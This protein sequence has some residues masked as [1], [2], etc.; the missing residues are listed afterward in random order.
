MGRPRGSGARS[1]VGGR[2]TRAGLVAL[3]CLPPRA[4]HAAPPD[5]PAS[6]AER[7]AVIRAAGPAIARRLA[8]PQ[9]RAGISRQKIDS[10]VNMVDT[11][12]AL[13]YLPSIMLRKR[14][15]G[16]TQA[17]VETRT[18]GVNS[19]ARSLVYVDDAPISALI[20]NNNTSGGPR[21]GM[22]A[23]EQI[24]RIDVL[25]GPFAAAYPGNAM[26]GVILITT[27]MPD[28]FEAT[29]RQGGGAQT[30]AGYRTHGTYGTATTAVTLG[31][32]I[33]RLSWFVS[34]NR[35]E[36]L[37][38]PL[39]FVTT[40]AMPRGAIPALSKTGAVANVAGA[41][42]LQHVTMNTVTGRLA[43]DITDWLRATYMVGYWTD[44]GRSRAQTYLRTAAG[45]AT[46]GGIGGFANGIY[47]LGAAHLSNMVALRTDTRGTWDGE[48]VFTAYDY[49]HDW[50]RN[51]AGVLAGTAL[52][53]GGAIASMAGSGWKTA[54]GRATWRPDAAHEVSF[55]GHWDRYMLEN[56][57]YDTNDW[58]ASATH[59]N[60]TFKT[61]GRGTTQTEA[62]WAQ[63]A[64]HVL[65]GW[66][67]TAG[68][69]MEF[70]QAFGGYNLAGTVGQARPRVH[71]AH[72]SPKATLAWR[73]DPLWEAKLSF[74]EAWRFPTVS[75]L[76][77]IVST[78]IT[79][80]L[81]NADLAPERVLSGE[82][83]IERRTADSVVRL[84]LFQE[85]THDALISQMTMLDAVYVTTNQNVTAIRNRG[86]EC[87]V[88]K[89]N[90]LGRDIDLSNSVT[91]VDSRILSDP[92]FVSA[93]GTIAAGK[94]VPYVPAWR[95]TLQLTWHATARL[96]L[97]GSL[98]YQG[99]VA[100]T[101]DNT[102]R[103]GHVFGAFDGFLV[104]DLHVR[105]GLTQRLT[106]DVGVDNVNNARYYLYH[107][108][109][110]RK[111]VGSLKARF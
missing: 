33:G 28:H 61:L 96:D 30:Y 94:H 92:G 75:E 20:S 41:S 9:T 77:Q 5:A 19:S 99:R 23:P 44:D 79:Y 100:S 88:Q 11:E 6:A 72:V 108:F 16:D 17:T 93:T 35:E 69:R 89:Q 110:M 101:I 31:D 54:D 27:R 76:Y 74:G 66:T 84:S 51:P 67:L 53:P 109:M 37:T 97:T 102:D 65:P 98:R 15:A 13:K 103:V 55:G 50:Q 111:W 87:V 1:A 45:A 81:P 83:S 85:N 71:A 26:G 68:G 39:F 10:T 38:Q 86:V 60:G 62:A 105:Y 78:G 29:I 40:A 107:P 73:I 18:W 4:G 104:A 7:I 22:V 90:L 2:A 57:T 49:L 47:T 3:A 32:R 21:W 46:Y 82:A 12:D 25:Y 80:A 14:N 43:Y 52:T 63:D 64:W 56:P 34:A 95:D 91:Y 59:G 70:W 58:Q 48:G 42:G 8:L 24:E 106:L 36:S